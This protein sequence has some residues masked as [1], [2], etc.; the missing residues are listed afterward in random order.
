[1]IEITGKRRFLIA[2]ILKENYENE[3]QIF[4]YVDHP[5]TFTDFFMDSS[6]NSVEDFYTIL[7]NF[8]TNEK[9]F[10]YLVIYINPYLQDKDFLKNQLSKL[11]NKYF[12]ITIIFMS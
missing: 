5:I 3:V 7:D 8:L 11:E 1:M 12:G 10:S 9:G 4:S 6:Q 2:R